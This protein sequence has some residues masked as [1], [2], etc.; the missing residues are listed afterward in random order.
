MLPWICN[1]VDTTCLPCKCR[2]IVILMLTI[3]QESK[4]LPNLMINFDQKAIF[5][6][7]YKYTLLAWLV[8]KAVDQLFS[9]YMLNTQKYFTVVTRIRY[10]LPSD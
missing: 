8:Q 3:S 1:T 9:L 4:C 2:S 5:C 10:F 7:F 6:G